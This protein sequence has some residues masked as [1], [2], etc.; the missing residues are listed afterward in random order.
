MAA[1]TAA[2]TDLQ[3]E[4]AWTAPT[5]AAVWGGALEFAPREGALLALVRRSSGA[6]RATFLVQKAITP[7]RGD[8]EHD[9]WGNV[10][11]TAK[12]WNRAVDIARRQD[13]LVGLCVLHTHPGGSGPPVWSV[14]DDSTDKDLGECFL[15]VGLL[16]P[17]APLLSLVASRGAL[18]GRAIRWSQ[19]DG[20]SVFDPIHR[21]RTIA[22]D[23]F[24]AQRTIDHPRAEGEDV[25]EF[26]DRSIRVFGREGQRQLAD[27]HIVVAGNGGVGS[28]VADHIARWGVGAVSLWDPDVITDVNI[29]R[30]SV[31]T[32]DDARARRH[33]APVLAAALRTF[34]LQRD[35]RVRHSD[36]DLRRSSELPRLLD[37]DIILSLV[38]D[39]RPRHFLNRLSYAHFIPV[40][41]GGSVIASTAEDDPH[42]EHGVVENGAVRINT[43]GPGHACLW[44]SGHLD[45]M[46][47]S[48]AFRTVEDR[49]ADRHRGYVEGLG[50]EHA[51]SVMPMNSLTSA[52][53]ELRLQDLIF[54]LS[55]RA[56]TELYYD[57]IPGTLA[58]VPRHRD[59]R[60]RHCN[61]FE[62]QGD[63]ADMPFADL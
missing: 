30:S 33:K 32:F 58:E 2:A 55:R 3:A 63:N 5:R 60:C 37:A 20:K 19:V 45:S 35:I 53:V 28:I 24:E 49:A 52:L 61:P 26:A 12:Y 51:P 43:V 17:G 39:P 62:G 57:M 44:C 22:A 41:D 16:P 10:S 11:L 1:P 13:G 9:K 34:A 15:G 21:V 42:C 54:I 7:E 47:L 36:R 48:K 50:P 31:Y 18:R 4:I 23:A 27:L 25:P 40:I 8:L 38:D 56:V 59:P 6:T 14:T 46:K 29:N